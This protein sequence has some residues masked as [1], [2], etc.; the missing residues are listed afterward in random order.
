[1]SKP[2]G[3]SPASIDTYFGEIDAGLAAAETTAGSTA[4]ADAAQAHAV[5]RANHTG[6]QTI[7]TVTGLQ[8]ALDAKQPLDADLT[9]L[10]SAGNST[11]LAATTAS[12]T[13]ALETKL[14]G[15][16]AGADV[17]RASSFLLMG[18]G[19]EVSQTDMDTHE[20]S[21]ARFFGTSRATVDALHQN[22]EV[23]FRLPSPLRGGTWTF[24]LF[25]SATTNVG[26]YSIA[27]SADGS[28]FSDRATVDGY[29]A[30]LTQSRTP[31]TGLV[32][33]DG[34][35]FVRLK[36]ATKNASSSGYFAR[37]SALAGVRTGA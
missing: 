33:P 13:T 2:A 29:A 12:F 16:A 11:V 1:M 36:V 27:T 3:V 8:A 15:I 17:S 30:S 19:P 26:I 32:I 28:A 21:S 34:D 14:G 22:A 20:I 9:A 37:F 7:A 35:A 10:A 4:K 18:V 31:A 24:V 23:V 5:Q 25:H 6:T